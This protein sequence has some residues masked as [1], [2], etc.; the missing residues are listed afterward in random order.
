[1]ILATGALHED[2][3]VDAAEVSAG[4]TPADRLAIMRD[5]RI[6]TYGAIALC[7]RS[8][9][10]RRPI[11]A[12]SLRRRSCTHRSSSRERPGPSERR[13]LM[14]GFP[15][16]AQRRPFR[17][18]R[19]PVPTMRLPS[20][21]LFTFLLGWLLVSFGSPRFLYRRRPRLPSLSATML[22]QSWGARPVM[23]SAPRSKSPNA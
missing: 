11:V 18:R 12:P 23:S 22:A 20:R 9:F 3:L 2:G 19:P 14:V 5:H 15:S 16:G 4:E 10:A 7:S 8:A 1:M 17:L 6:G 21:W 13:F